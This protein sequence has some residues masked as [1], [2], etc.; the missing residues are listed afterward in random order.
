MN[1]SKFK[2]GDVVKIKP[3][4][5]GWGEEVRDAL[6]IIGPGKMYPTATT[7]QSISEC[8]EE[9]PDDFDLVA[10]A[11]PKLSKIPQPHKHAELIKKWADGAKIQYLESDSEGSWF[12]IA[13]PSW[14]L[15]TVYRVEP[16]YPE[17]TLSHVDLHD[18]YRPAST[19]TIGLK[20]VA[21]E[22]IKQYI[23]ENNL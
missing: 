20:A 5:C 7:S 3:T 14:D 11:G 8:V 23:I 9:Y 13:K 15:G 4:A 10:S 12:N 19:M 18:I 21:D 2:D 22:A 17:T 6:H 16:E 1:N